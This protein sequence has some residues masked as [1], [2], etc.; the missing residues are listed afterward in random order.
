MHL[1][2]RVDKDGYTLFEINAEDAEMFL[3]VINPE[4]IDSKRQVKSFKL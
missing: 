4:Y 3:D 2:C 1:N